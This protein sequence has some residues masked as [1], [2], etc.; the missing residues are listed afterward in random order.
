MAILNVNNLTDRAGLLYCYAAEYQDPEDGTCGSFSIVE[1]CANLSGLGEEFSRDYGPAEQW[2][3]V[4]IDLGEL[5][6]WAHN[7]G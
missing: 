1:S 4:K 3:G 5:I 2:D 7:L 6:H